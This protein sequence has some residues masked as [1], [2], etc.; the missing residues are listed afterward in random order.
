MAVPDFQTLMRPLL[1][2]YADGEERAIGVVRDSLAADFHLTAAELEERIPSGKAK[3][4][5]NRVGWA[6]TYLY[7]TGLLGRPRRSVYRITERGDQVLRSHPDRIDLA[8]LRQF[9]ELKD[10]LAA[11][12]STGDP[13]PEQVGVLDLGAGQTAT[14]EE[15]IDAAYSEHRA[16]VAGELLDRIRQHTP[17]FFEQLV[18]DV[19]IAMGYGGSRAQAA[20]RL[21]KSGDSGLDGVIS[22]DRL[23]LDLIYV[24]AK[25]WKDDSTVGRPDVQGFVGALQGAR[26]PKGVFITA[27]T[28]SSE[29]RRYAETVSPRVIL[30]DG[31]T[32]AGLMIDHDVGVSGTERYVLKRMDE[33][34]FGPI[35]D[36]GA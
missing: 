28:F 2:H 13:P 25:R 10:F 11:R 18:L 30:I 17:E 14:P 1:A 22:E 8:V 3:T 24:Q 12:S 7:R 31:P 26:A 32:L 35:G 20:T 23:G 15:T 36:G 4:F 29:A 21:G 34:Y 33:D 19:L 5:Q 16:A 9:P 6:A 27:S